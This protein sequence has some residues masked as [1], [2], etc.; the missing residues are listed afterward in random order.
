M[1]DQHHAEERGKKIPNG[2]LMLSIFGLPGRAFVG[3]WAFLVATIIESKKSQD[4]PNGRGLGAGGLLV[5]HAAFTRRCYRMI[6]RE[7]SLSFKALLL[8]NCAGFQEGIVPHTEANLP[9]I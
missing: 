3:S 7:V 8:A 5:E 9:T 4:A 6:I 2:E 1:L